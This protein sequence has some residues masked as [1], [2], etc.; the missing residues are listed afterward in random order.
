M[1]PVRPEKSSGLALPRRQGELIK[2]GAAPS[3]LRSRPSGSPESA[4][5]GLPVSAAFEQEA[6][7]GRG[8]VPLW[9]SQASVDDSKARLGLA[10]ILRVL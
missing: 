2:C 7:W 5:Q 6:G 1:G 3:R 4:L 10:G 9:G 8:T